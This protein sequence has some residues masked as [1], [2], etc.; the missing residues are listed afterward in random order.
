MVSSHES[1]GEQDVL[2]AAVTRA[3]AG[4]SSDEHFQP[5]FEESPL[6]ILVWRRPG[7]W[8]K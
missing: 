1:V 4:L 2:V 3:A 6:G 5:L 8:H 7:A